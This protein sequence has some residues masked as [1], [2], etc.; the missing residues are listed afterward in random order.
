MDDGTGDSVW[1]RVNR[2]FDP[3]CAVEVR[4]DDDC[5]VFKALRHIEEGESL[6]FDYTSTEE[7]VFA[8]PFIDFDTGRPVGQAP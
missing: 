7:A 1:A 4:P 3:N 5:V 8:A 6:S 2:S